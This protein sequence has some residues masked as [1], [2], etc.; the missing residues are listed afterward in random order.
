[1]KQFREIWDKYQDLV[2]EGV[3]VEPKISEAAALDFFREGMY[4]SADMATDR[5]RTR[6]AGPKSEE[7]QK[8]AEMIIGA[9]NGP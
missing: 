1:M 2:A 9:A 8:I 3:I 4:V 7:A 6:S 5:N